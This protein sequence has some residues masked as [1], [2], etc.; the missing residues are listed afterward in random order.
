MSYT[1]S[2]QKKFS[3]I[4]DDVRVRVRRGVVRLYGTVADLQDVDL[5]EDVVRNRDG[6]VDVINHLEVEGIM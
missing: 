1:E 4:S 2:L 5:V 3:T 6:V